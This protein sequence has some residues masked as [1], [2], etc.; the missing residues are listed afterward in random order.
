MKPLLHR[1]LLLVAGAS[2][3]ALGV[4][5]AH[6]GWLPSWARLGGSGSARDGDERAEET[7]EVSKADEDDEPLKVVRLA[8]ADLAR[9]F[10]VETAPA[11]KERHAHTLDGNAEAAYNGRR[12]AEVLA[13]VSGVLREVRVDLGQ[14]VRK[15]DVLAVL[16]SAQV[17]NAKVQFHA[18]RTT[19]DLAKVTYDRTVK[20]SREGA[21]PAKNELEDLTALNRARANLMEAE[22]RLRNLGF[23]DAEIARIARAD[24]ASNV[25]EVLAPIDATITAWDATPGEAVEPTTQLFA[26]ADTTTMWLWVDVYEAS[27]GS[28]AVGQLVSFT[29]SGTEAP[30]FS[31]RV[32]SVGTEVNPTTRTT[33]VRAE[34]ANPEGRLRANQF[35]RARIRTEPE[36]EAVVVPRAAV[37]SDGKRQIVFVPVDDRS[38]RPQLVVTRPTERDDVVEVVKGLDAGERVV[39]TRSYMLKGELFKGRLGA[40]DND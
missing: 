7:R 20:L 21:T 22:Q 18:A 30:A 31:G 12:T 19:V 15:G 38:F 16:D 1:L 10:G 23:T 25:L 28:V 37:Q 40:A 39:T 33:R 32:T 5:W 34:L 17:S 4:V 13:R 6:P 8:S 35:G 27:I 14:V 3:L 2:L 9:R 29:I 24:D 11:R 36:H 26:M